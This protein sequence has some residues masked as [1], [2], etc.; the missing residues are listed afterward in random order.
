M[1]NGTH[2]IAVNTVDGLF[3]NTSTGIYLE[4]RLLNIVHDLRQSPYLFTANI[5]RID[6]RFLLRYTNEA[7]ENPS[8]EVVAN[9]VFIA[10]NKTQINIQSSIESIESV[11]VYDVLGRLLF[12]K[13]KLKNNNFVINNLAV[14]NQTLIVKIVLENRKTVTK[15]IIF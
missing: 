13:S 2:K 14:S 8:F 11:A 4:D 6:N 9:A 7:L 1:E 15:K 10:N 5:G 3:E 12:E